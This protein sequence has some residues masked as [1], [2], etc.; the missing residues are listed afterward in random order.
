LDELLAIAGLKRKEVFI[1]NAVKHFR[2][3]PRGKR[4]LHKKPDA[5]QVNACH[6][7]LDREIGTVRPAVIVALGATALRALTGSALS[8]ESARN[9]E[10]RLSD[11]ARILATYHPSAILR[12][13][14]ARAEQLR[15]NLEHDLRSAARIATEVAKNRESIVKR[16]KARETNPS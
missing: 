12:A 11:G 10:L 2:W 6:V 9:R 3:E 13:E 14:G 4:R 1:T 8:I 7:W 5:A 15:S 16:P